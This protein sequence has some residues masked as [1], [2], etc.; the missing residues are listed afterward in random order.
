MPGDHM[1][2]SEDGGGIDLDKLM[3]E[4]D[5]NV[6]LFGGLC[7]VRCCVGAFF[8]FPLFCPLFWSVDTKGPGHLL[9]DAKRL[10]KGLLSVVGDDV[11]STRANLVFFQ[12]TKKRNKKNRI[13]RI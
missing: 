11:R 4:D 2:E 10:F 12:T 3:L 13:L 9:C 6:E 1:K 7:A 8:T 5:L